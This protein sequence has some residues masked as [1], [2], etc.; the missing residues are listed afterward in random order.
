MT[1]IVDAIVIGAGISGLCAAYRLQQSGRDVLVLERNTRVGGVI[2]SERT[3]GY[4]IEHGPNSIQSKTPLLQS[5]IRELNLSGAQIHASTAARVRYI[6]R[7]SK[8]VQAPTSPPALLTSKLFGT[9]AK[10]RVMREPFVPPGDP[11]DDESVADFIRRRLGEEVLNYAVNPFV[12]GVYAGDPESLSV[13]HTFPSLFDLEQTYGSIL[14]GHVEKR[15]NATRLAETSR[16]FSF[17][18][19]VGQLIDALADRLPNIE[20][21]HE[22]VAVAR[23][24][25]GWTVSTPGGDFHAR[26]VIFAA[27]LHATTKMSLPDRVPTNILSD[28]TYAPLSVVYQ[29]YRRQDIRHS[30]DGFGVLVPEVE[31]SVGILGS[32]FTS[33]IF[34]DRSP[35]GHVLLTTFVGG[36]RH[37]DQA[38]GAS[39][40]LH[41]DVRSDLNSLLGLRSEPT[42]LRHVFWPHA[43]PQ[44]EI[45]YD[46]VIDAISRLETEMPGW[47]FAGSFRTGVS[48]GDSAQ[49]GDDAGNRCHGFLQ[50]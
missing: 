49:S 9:G 29:G 4:L 19:G 10:L 16:M 32:L 23:S 33:S 7:R 47:F 50:S 17:R 25:H 3:N 28:V 12:A 35:E 24:K 43:I 20:T 15:R 18:D 31:R 36:M 13:K 26:S 27:P 2:R 11:Q 40:S 37:P 30:L 48:V 46:A 42:F 1:D 6:V 5:L 41:R 8:L 21:D 38:T 14:K 39:E 45:G 34:P 22:V 44:Y